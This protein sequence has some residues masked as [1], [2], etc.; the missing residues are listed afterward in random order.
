MLA[1]V[2]GLRPLQVPGPYA[3]LL[4]QTNGDRADVLAL[5]IGLRPLQVPGPPQATQA[6]PARRSSPCA[7]SGALLAL[8]PCRRSL[9]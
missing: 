2:I 5:V 3:D 1:L 6:R 9:V 7:P 4:A 8:A